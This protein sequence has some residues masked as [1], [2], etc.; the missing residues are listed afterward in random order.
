MV[1]FI[2][3][4]KKKKKTTNKKPNNLKIKQIYKKVNKTKKEK[5]KEKENLLYSPKNLNLQ[6]SSPFSDLRKKYKNYIKKTQG[7]S[8]ISKRNSCDNFLLETKS[9]KN[10]KE[11]M[12][13]Q[14]K[15]LM[16]LLL[17]NQH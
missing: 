8:Y 17:I 2:K 5:E 7:S 13:I 9:K 12:V 10:F 15:K 6:N 1:Q 14:L 3:W 16:S 4:K 11:N